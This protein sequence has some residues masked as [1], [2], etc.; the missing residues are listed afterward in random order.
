[1]GFI[2]NSKRWQIGHV[3]VLACPPF[4]GRMSHQR[5]EPDIEEKL[6]LAIQGPPRTAPLRAIPGTSDN[7][8]QPGAA[9]RGPIGP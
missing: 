4:A 5:T 8:A 2:A 6:S 7:L 9:E 3:Y 1:M